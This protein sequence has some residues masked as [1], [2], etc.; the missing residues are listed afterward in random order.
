LIYVLKHKIQIFLSILPN[1]F[2]PHRIGGGRN[3][4]HHIQG[5]S[6]IELLGGLALFLYGMHKLSAGIK[7]IGEII[8]GFGS[9][10]GRRAKSC[11]TDKYRKSNWGKGWG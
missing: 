5:V 4:R 11:S 2:G 6:M 8:L 1:F 3:T 9:G 10:Q 7:N